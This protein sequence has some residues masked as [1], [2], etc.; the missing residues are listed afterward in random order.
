MYNVFRNEKIAFSSEASIKD[1]GFITIFFCD[2][3]IDKFYRNV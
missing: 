2:S 1:E 3:E